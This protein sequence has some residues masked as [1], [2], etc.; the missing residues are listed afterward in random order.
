MIE[1]PESHSDVTIHIAHPVTSS[2][3]SFALA[4]IGW[5]SLLQQGYSSLNIPDL[6]SYAYPQI[7]AGSS[8]CYNDKVLFE[9]PYI[10]HVVVWRV[11]VME[12]ERQELKLP[13]FDIF[14]PLCLSA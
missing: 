13:L 14:C 7:N 1:P 6:D 4:P 3:L 5:P 2:Y 10:F 11:V 8:H 9:Q 12:R